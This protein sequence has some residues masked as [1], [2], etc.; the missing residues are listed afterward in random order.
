MAAV[1]LSRGRTIVLLLAAVLI[2]LADHFN[3]I[4]DSF[5]ASYQGEI[6]PFLARFLRGITNLCPF[7][8]GDLLFGY[9]AVLFLVRFIR[10]FRKRG[11]FV[12][13]LDL[14]G[15]LA[16]VYLLFCGIWGLNYLGPKFQKSYQDI[17]Y[18][19]DDLINT[20]E[21]LTKRINEAHTRLV[22]DTTAV[23]KSGLDKEVIATHFTQMLN[24][25]AVDLFGVKKG[26][27]V[28]KYSLVSKA[29]DYLGFSGYINPITLEIQINKGIPINGYGATI[30]HEISHHLGVASET[31]ANFV[32]Y[33]MC[34]KS[35]D[36]AIRYSGYSMALRYCISD[37][38]RKSPKDYERMIKKINKGILLDWQARRDYWRQFENPI[39]P[40][41]HQFY[42]LFL[43][44][45][46]Q[47]A[48]MRSYSL[49]VHLVV[50]YFK[51]NH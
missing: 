27:F 10:C 51:E 17:V 34:E 39:R 40:Y 18:S 45:T 43:K 35:H 38:Y 21:A 33:L 30:A 6:Y 37:L 3:Q 12:R 11:F 19:D 48:G 49:M 2:F 26:D 1:I 28:V 8:L 47:P 14:L 24:R 46:G 22:Q 4:P 41:Y 29:L 16:V 44:S 20:C 23:F 31:E 7:S 13:L 50:D 36:D 9:L 15:L 25:G 5:I 32:A 42:G